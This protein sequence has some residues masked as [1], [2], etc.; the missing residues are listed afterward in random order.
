[1]ARLK[2][3]VSD[4]QLRAVLQLAFAHNTTSVMKDPVMLV[5]PGHGGPSTER[6]NYR[7]PLLLLFGIVGL[8][9]LV[10]CAN[11]AGLSLARG[12]A[13]QHELAVRV[14]LGSGRWR[15]LRQSLTESLLLAFAGGLF[16]VLIAIWSRD[17]M[18]RLLI[19]SADG[20]RYD[21]SLDLTVLSFQP[22]GDADHC[23]AFGNAAGAARESGRPA[24][25]TQ[26]S[27][28]SHGTA[29][30]CRQNPRRRA[31]RPLAPA[32][33]H[34]W[35]LSPIARQPPPHRRGFHD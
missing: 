4:V 17:A 2:P 12:A 25:R 3:G 23:L 13:R 16:G 11:L 5:E 33:R 26:G 19:G 1:M 32:P 28:R 15:L 9:M 10:A 27:R 31:N 29:T 21:L 35:S 6:E 34:R 14:A 22:H 7:K 30:A 8:V 24:R 20:L 18:A